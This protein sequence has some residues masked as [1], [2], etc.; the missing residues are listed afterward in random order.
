MAAGVPSHRLIFRYWNFLH[1]HQDILT[2]YMP[3]LRQAGVG[4]FRFLKDDPP[5]REV[6][7]SLVPQ[8][9]SNVRWEDGTAH[10]TGSWDESYLLF[11]L[12]KAEYAYGIRLKYTYWN[13]DNTLPFV[14]LHWRDDEAKQFARDRF[15]NYSATGDHANWVR[16][17]WGQTKAPESTLTFWVR[18]TVKEI[19]LHPDLRPGVMKVSELVLL[20][21][22]AGQ[23]SDSEKAD[24]VSYRPIWVSSP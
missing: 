23:I 4:S 20:T 18:D 24:T 2:E 7:I 19:R 5:F 8:H 9:L 21:A 6:S 13:S 16:G 3:M 11:S 17:T 10:A 12:P 1:P 22:P 14:F 15:K